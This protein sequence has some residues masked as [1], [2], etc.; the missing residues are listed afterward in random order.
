MP[1]RPWHH[2]VS[3]DDAGIRLD[4]LLVR[5]L[6]T[7]VGWD[8]SRAAI[9]RLIMA[10]AVRVDGRPVRRPGLPLPAGAVARAHVH[11]ARLSPGPSHEGLDPQDILF[12]DADLL[13]IAK[14]AGI[15]THAAAD[16]RRSDMVSLAREYLA[17][18]DPGR[19]PYVAVHQRLDRDTSGVLLFGIAERAN[20]G[21][22]RAFADREVTKVYHAIVHAPRRRLPE[23]WVVDVPLA[24]AGTGR[25][26]RMASDP[27]GQPARTEFRV[28][29]RWRDLWLVDARP[30]TGRRHQ[31]RAHLAHRGLPI[32]G[33]TRYGAPADPGTP[34]VMLHC[35]RLEL[36]HPVNGQPLVIECPWPADFDHLARVR[37]TMRDR[38]RS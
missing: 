30:Y 13:A 22:A 15:P 29:E 35:A 8:I 5:E 25:S 18:R 23:R 11:A 10:G 7:I 28:L 21:L 2:V 37:R 36:R 17:G 19:P 20:Q 26:S 33:D 32:A 14:P 4:T 27:R 38:Q 31:V 24:P 1:A 6:A 12:E 3:L 9:R 16:A 34:R